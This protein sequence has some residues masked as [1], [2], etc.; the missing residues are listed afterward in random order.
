LVSGAHL[1]CRRRSANVNIKMTHVPRSVLAVMSRLPWPLHPGLSQV[2][3]FALH[4]DLHDTTFDATALLQ[5]YPLTLTRL[6]DWI[7]A[8]CVPSVSG[9]SAQA[10]VF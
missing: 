8:T 1:A 9:A 3:A 7:R 6:D 4:D 2:M 5:R 10:K